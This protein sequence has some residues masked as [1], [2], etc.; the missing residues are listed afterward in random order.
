[1]RGLNE[2][3]L[4]Y[5]RYLAARMKKIKGPK[6]YLSK[7]NFFMGLSFWF[8]GIGVNL[9]P[10]I[11]NNI[12]TGVLFIKTL[13]MY[14]MCISSIF[15]LV[16]EFFLFYPIIRNRN[17]LKQIRIFLIVINLILILIYTL[18]FFNN[19]LYQLVVDFMCSINL[20]MFIFMVIGATLLFLFKSLCAYKD[21]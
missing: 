16:L 4:F 5:Y 8:I 6:R 18:L 2:Y 3:S 19:S 13:D 17:W 20:I 10:C 1:M 7:K 12:V 14:F 9:I 21:L 11:Y 15:L